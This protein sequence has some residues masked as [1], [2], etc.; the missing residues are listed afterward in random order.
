MKNICDILCIEFI[1]KTFLQDLTE[2]QNLSYTH[3]EIIEQYEKYTLTE[4]VKA[5]KE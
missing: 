3:F 4:L 5:V 1:V 2:Q